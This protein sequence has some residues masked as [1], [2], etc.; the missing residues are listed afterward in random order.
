MI[1]NEY[2]YWML[3]SCKRPCSNFQQTTFS[4]KKSWLKWVLCVIKHSPM[5]R[6]K[7]CFILKDL[8]F[9]GKKN[10]PLVLSESTGRPVISACLEGD[11][12]N[13]P[14]NLHFFRCFVGFY[15]VVCR[16]ELWESI[17]LSLAQLWPEAGGTWWLFFAI[18]MLRGW[19]HR[20]E[21]FPI[22]KHLNEHM[23]FLTTIFGLFGSL[24]PLAL[25]WGI[26][27]YLR[28]STPMV[29]ILPR[30]RYLQVRRDDELPNVLQWWVDRL[31]LP[32]PSTSSGWDQGTGF[33][34]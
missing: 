31:S 12:P 19:C 9:S 14:P 32:M 8:L 27:G 26:P 21:F 22:K 23:S 24:G 4:K 16:S 3:I 28:P 17:Q 11:E 20:Q 25:N 1:V 2:V 29:P 18:T 5:N 15:C 13:E 34:P 30:N 10:K 7:N 33:H 6:T